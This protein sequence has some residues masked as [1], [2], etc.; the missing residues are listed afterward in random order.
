M[1]TAGIVILAL[2]MAFITYE[3]ERAVRASTAACGYAWA[4]MGAAMGHAHPDTVVF[5]PKA[6]PSVF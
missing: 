5:C 4:A 2:W 6:L 1:K 3:V